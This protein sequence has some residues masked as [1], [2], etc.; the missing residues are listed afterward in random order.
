MLIHAF[1]LLNAQRETEALPIFLQLAERE[2]PGALATLAQLHWTATLVQR[3]YSKARDYY[4]RAGEAGHALCRVYATNLMASGYV[5]QR[6]WKQ[7]MERLRHEA[8]SDPL[9]A[10]IVSILARMDLTDEGDPVT[11][12][13]GER[14]SDA[15]DVQLF[16]GA[17]SLAECDYLFRMKKSDYARANV[18]D[19]ATGIERVDPVRT[20]DETHIAW[21]IEN[22]L[23]HVF[24]RRLAALS[25]TDALQGEPLQLLR[26]RP[27]QQYYNHYDYIPGAANQRIMTALLYLNED[28]TGGETAFPRID[29]KVK[30]GRGDVLLFRNSQPDGR[31]EQ[32]S[33]H[34]G[35]PVISGV[36][37]IAT[38]WMRANT[39]T[40]LSI[41][42]H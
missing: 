41:S 39:Y 13:K 8:E 38:R 29:L 18:I 30:G 6:D 42:G 34:A 11:I 32:N 23:V 31:R 7:A 37:H 27:G 28:Y 35:T 33:E 40:A 10:E 17:F 5:G 21:E 9:R 20:A 24:N 2:E 1:S 4:H 3:D 26:Y 19:E 12:P 25:N 14:L 15:I 22:P 16:R 36:K